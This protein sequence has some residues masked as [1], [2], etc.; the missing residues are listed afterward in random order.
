MKK[1]SRL[2]LLC[3]LTFS[4][5]SEPFAFALDNTGAKPPPPQ[6][7]SPNVIITSIAGGNLTNADGSINENALLDDVEIYNQS[8]LPIDLSNWQLSFDTIGCT[9]AA[10][11]DIPVPDGWILPKHY[12]NFERG[13]APQSP[14]D[15]SVLF[16]FPDL[17]LFSGCKLHSVQLFEANEIEQTVTITDFSKMPAQHKQRALSPNSTR[18]V[19]GDFALDYKLATSPFYSEALY[20]PPPASN[21]LQI[22]EILPHARD[23]SP[24][25]TTTPDCVDYVK[26]Y[27]PTNTAVDLSQYRLRIGYKGQGSSITNAFHFDQSLE[28]GKYFTLATRDDGD[29]ISITDTGNFVWLEDAYG[30]ASYGPVVQ[31]PSASSTTKVGW[32][33]AFDGQTWR[34]TSAPHPF[35]ANYFPPEIVAPVMPD[36]PSYV[37]CKVNQYRSPETHRCRNIV[38]SASTLVPC[39]PSQIR[40]PE[41]NRC[42]SILAAASGLQPCKAGQTRNPETNRCKS[43][44]SVSNQLKP[45]Q[46]GWER[47]PETNRC[48]KG[49]VLG[50]AT[51]KVQ[52]IKSPATSSVRWLLI[53]SVVAGALAYGLYEWRQEFALKFAS[54]KKFIAHIGRAKK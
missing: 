23:C 35:D 39:K 29:A 3:L 38:V 34:W 10:P 31:Y 19:T 52:D 4:L 7:T 25:D 44:T 41:T 8:D 1:F 36:T 28:P 43:A 20:S 42:R 18:S 16:D 47:N 6:P 15:F 2:L 30:V 27:N 53:G 22:L 32:A 46:P 13:A 9:L 54:S 49:S 51:T 5:A 17:G 37:P 45:C 11:I 12:L 40:N 33:W 21:G 26:L 14:N 48:R 24:D 50:S